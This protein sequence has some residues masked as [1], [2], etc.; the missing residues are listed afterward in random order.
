MQNR[1]ESR[2]IRD[3]EPTKIKE[4][5]EINKIKEEIIQQ[6]WLNSNISIG[7]DG[8]T[9]KILLNT[10]EKTTIIQSEEYILIDKII[11][12]EKQYPLFLYLAVNNRIYFCIGNPF[13]IENIDT[14][15]YS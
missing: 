3:F 9:L 14:N 15:L 6:G 12:G 10:P 1:W 4:I 7:I 5:K 2:S 11:I 8:L 13:G